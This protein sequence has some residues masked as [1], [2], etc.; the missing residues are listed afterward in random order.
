MGFFA[1]AHGWPT[2]K[3]VTHI[4]NNETWYSFTLPKEDQKNI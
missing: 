1:A 4:L 3:S 2:L